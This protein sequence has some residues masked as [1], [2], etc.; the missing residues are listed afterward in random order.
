[1]YTITHVAIFAHAPRRWDLLHKRLTALLN[2]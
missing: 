1:M 2:I